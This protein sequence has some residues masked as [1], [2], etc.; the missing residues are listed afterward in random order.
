MKRKV[1]VSLY[2][3]AS[4][5]Y[6]IAEGKDGYTFLHE[7]DMKKIK[8]IDIGGSGKTWYAKLNDVK[9]K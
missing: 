1:P 2:V 6:V 9:H 4:E 5:G 8:F 7:R 3:D